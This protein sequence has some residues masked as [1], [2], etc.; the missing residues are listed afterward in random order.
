M[1]SWCKAG[2]LPLSQA[3]PP[4][5]ALLHPTQLKGQLCCL[6]TDCHPRTCGA[7]V[8]N[9]PHRLY[10]PR[11]SS[12]MWSGFYVPGCLHPFQSPSNPASDL[13]WLSI[14]VRPSPSPAEGLHSPAPSSPAPS[15]CSFHPTDSQAPSRN[16]QAFWRAYACVARGHGTW[17]WVIQTTT[18]GLLRFFLGCSLGAWIGLSIP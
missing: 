16:Q 11:P 18:V 3:H 10:H 2:K 6:F 17:S 12:W 1:F 9:L 5:C 14:T 8:L 13:P 15:C 4:L 7:L